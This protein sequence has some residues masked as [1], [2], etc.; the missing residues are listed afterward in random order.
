MSWSKKN[1][2][3]LRALAESSM[4]WG[5]GEE[6]VAYLDWDE[7]LYYLWFEPGDGYVSWCEEVLRKYGDDHPMQM[8][9]E[10]RKELANIGVQTF[11]FLESVNSYCKGKCGSD[12]PYDC[13]EFYEDEFCGICGA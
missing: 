3:D 6:V 8:L 2:D 9:N 11:G 4:R 5:S 7:R 12:D 1:P 10:L 13:A